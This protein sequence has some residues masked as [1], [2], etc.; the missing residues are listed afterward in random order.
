MYSIC[1]NSLE[2]H[3]I[4]KKGPN[5]TSIY[6]NTMWDEKWTRGIND[7]LDITDEKMT[8]LV[9]TAKETT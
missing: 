1:L 2:I 8:E 5:L 9:D 3:K 4:F 7:R 6:E